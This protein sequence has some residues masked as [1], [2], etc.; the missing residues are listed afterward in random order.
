M[1]ARK[2]LKVPPHI[3][4]AFLADMRAYLRATSE[5]KRDEIA[6]HQLRILSSYFRPG[7]KKMQLSDVRNLFELMRDEIEE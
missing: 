3:A 6:A 7:D 4:R 1:I 2:P 5:L